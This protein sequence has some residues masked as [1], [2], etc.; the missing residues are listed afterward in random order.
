MLLSSKLLLLKGQYKA[1]P[2]IPV[3]PIPIKGAMQENMQTLQS[4]V[5]LCFPLH[6]H[7]FIHLL[8]GV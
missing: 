8:Q 6:I 2:Y 3:L 1:P 5:K 7:R 4:T